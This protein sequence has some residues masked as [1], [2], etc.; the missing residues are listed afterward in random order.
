MTKKV[1]NNRYYEKLCEKLGYVFRNRSLLDA[2][3]THRSF[4][5]NNNERL[6]FLGDS[7]LNFTIAEKLY[8]HFP[9]A[10]EGDLSRLR[11]ALVKGDT[12]AEIAREMGLGEF[13]NLGEGE[14]KSGGFRRASIL[15]D[16]LE[17]VIGAIYLDSD[18]HQAKDC[19]LSW[20]DERL[21]KVSLLTGEKDSKSQL[22]EWLQGRRN[23]LPQYSVVNVKGESHSQEFTVSCTISLFPEPTI[24]HATSR[25]N[26][27][28]EAAQLMLARIEEVYGKL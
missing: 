21:R 11:A 22:Q 6:E 13:L 14:L 12:L 24:A 27:E 2:A 9:E 19:I 5:S 1:Q 10:P 20:I 17:A 7:I 15:A 3:L 16:A 26:A 28:K 4:S 18:I 23:P 25:K 8:Q